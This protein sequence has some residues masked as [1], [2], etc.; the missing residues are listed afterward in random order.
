MSGTGVEFEI[1]ES[2][3]VLCSSPCEVSLLH[4]ERK[5]RRKRE[6]GKRKGKGRENEERKTKR[7][8][9]RIRR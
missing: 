8:S 5:S 2:S 6:W 9:Q 7:E 1:L 4:V 3:C